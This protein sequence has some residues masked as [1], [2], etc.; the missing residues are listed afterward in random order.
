MVFPLQAVFQWISDALWTF[1]VFFAHCSM[2]RA[3]GVWFVKRT[4]RFLWRV[5]E[6]HQA[7]CLSYSTLQ[8][9]SQS[10]GVVLFNNSSYIRGDHLTFD[11]GFSSY[12]Y[13]SVHV[14]VC[15]QMCEFLVK[16]FYL[17]CV[18]LSSL[19]KM[20][21]NIKYLLTNWRFGL[22]W[23]YTV[24]NFDL[25]ALTL[26]Q[27]ITC[28]IQQIPKLLFPY[29]PHSQIIIISCYYLP[30]IRAIMDILIIL[31]SH[32]GCLKIIFTHPFVLCSASQRQWLGCLQKLFIFHHHSTKLCKLRTRRKI[33]FF[34][35]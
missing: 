11:R 26:L 13:W 19:E 12:C 31:W 35:T 27:C 9:K 28:S 32:F 3:F 18:L 24:S 23:K 6:Q 4:T 5:K 1:T 15:N 34:I 10:F 25:E 2:T 21:L 17:H 7:W 14:C 29:S 20:L 8:E 33:F 22:Y 16:N 30:I